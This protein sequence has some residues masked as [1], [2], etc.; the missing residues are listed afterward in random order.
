MKAN[1]SPPPVFETDEDRTW[2]MVKLPIHEVFLG[3]TPGAEIS[4]RQYEIYLLLKD[5]PSLIMASH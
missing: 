3:M 4:K 2:F 1:G 5:K